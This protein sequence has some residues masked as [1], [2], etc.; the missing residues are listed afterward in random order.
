MIDIEVIKLDDVYLQ[1]DASEA[2]IREIVDVFTFDMPN[3]KFS[4]AY[5]ARRWDGKIRLFSDKTRKLYTGLLPYLC[6]HAKEHGYT[7]DLDKSVPLPKEK[8]KSEEALAFFDDYL[9]IHSGGNPIQPRDYQ[10]EAFRYCLGA[11]RC[12]IESATSSGKSLIIYGL[13]RFYEEIAR[14][15]GKKILIIVPSIGLVHQM[16]SDF[17][18]YS[19]GISWSAKSNCHMVFGGQEKMDT[20]KT[21]IISTYQS[22][23]E[24]DKK[25]FKNF[26][27]VV[28]DEAHKF[29]ASTLKNIMQKLTE[30]PYR[31]AFT[32]SLQEDNSDR[33]IIEGLFG[34]A[35]A[36][37]TARELIEMNHA[38]DFEVECI[39]FNYSAD[40]CKQVKGMTFQQ[41]REFVCSI[42]ERMD[43]IHK[44]IENLEGNTL[45]LFELVQKHG[46][47]LYDYIRTRTKR[48][49]YY[50]V[51]STEAYEREEIRKIIE[52]E[53]NCIILASYGVFSTGVSIKKIHNTIFAGS[54]GKSN[55]RVVQSIG[56]Q[57]RQHSTKSKTKLYDLGDNFST[58]E[59][60]NFLLRH[61]I[62]RVNIY[63]KENHPF[64]VVPINLM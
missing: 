55:I 54:P 64:K 12:V 49:V 63:T 53:D 61:M 24:M 18:D 41:E 16:Y 33:L 37:V 22:I 29:K 30:C 1:V 38:P 57:L 45:V 26:C 60:K 40:M 5:K 43:F 9:K 51:G 44:L 4:P 56:R 27:V 48:K 6:V 10:L 7:I 52:N 28:G 46:E 50:V 19:S 21:I 23:Y 11:S 58:K 59:R 35:K 39:V 34:R 31:F 17:E 20:D 25:Y 14:K 32:G 47:I 13:C 2:I 42:P 3:A 15:Q 36:I 8:P 62:E